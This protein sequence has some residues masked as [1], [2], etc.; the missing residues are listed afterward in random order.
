VSLILE[1]LKKL[2]RDKK[3]PERGFL[4]VGAVPWPAPRPRRWMPAAVVVAAG[5]VAGLALVLAWR[6]RVHEDAPGRASVPTTIA[7]AAPVSA[8]ALAAAPTTTLPPSADGRPRASETRKPAPAAGIEVP[9]TRAAAAPAAPAEAGTALQLQA[10][11]K[12]DGKPIAVLNNRVVH[13]GDHFDGVT[14]VRIGVDE[15]EI[16]VQGR[17]RT[18]RF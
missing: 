2:D 4:V 8:N 12:R 1:A 9:A 7:A 10:I 14:I 3:A 6:T 17:R 11:S 18:L 16:E 5:A 15:V 13:E